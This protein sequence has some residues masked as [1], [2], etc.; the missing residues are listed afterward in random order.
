M[1]LK[2]GGDLAGAIAAFRQAIEVKPDFEKAHYNLGIALRAQGKTGAAR[3]ELDELTALRDFRAR[4]AQAKY[5][6]LQGVD[7]PEAAEAR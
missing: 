2:A 4:L 3:K 7:A 5:L 1:E 6:T